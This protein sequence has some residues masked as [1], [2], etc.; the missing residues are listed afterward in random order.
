LPANAETVTL[1]KEINSVDIERSDVQKYITE[2]TTYR[3]ALKD[4]TDT[5]NAVEPKIKNKQIA[6]DTKK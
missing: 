6:L 5:L 3:Q 1:T 4:A 2:L